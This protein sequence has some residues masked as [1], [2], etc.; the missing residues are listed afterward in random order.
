[1][2]N[3]WIALLL[4]IG[5]GGVARPIAEIPPIDGEGSDAATEQTVVAAPWNPPRDDL[6]VLSVLRQPSES[7]MV[8][9]RVSFDVGSMEDPPGKEGLTS[10]TAALMAGGGLG[11]LSYPQVVERLY[12]MAASLGTHVGRDQTVFVG[13]AH[14]DHIEGFYPLFRDMLLA[15]AL[16]EQDF[17][18]LQ[19]QALS[20]LT[21]GLRGSND[22]ALGQETLQAMLYEGHPYGNPSVGTEA[23]IA[24]ITL[25]DVRDHARRMFCAG[26]ATLGLAGG[27]SAEL[28]GRLRQ[29]LARLEGE[30]C[31]GRRSL[32]DAPEGQPRIWLV[33]K[34][35]AASVAISMGV[36]LDVTRDHPDYA[37]L[38]LAAAYL[39]Q[40]R[41]FAGR[42]MQKMRGDR[43]LNYGDYAYAE[44]FMEHPGTRFPAANVSRRQQ[45]FS[46]WVRPVRR[47]QAHFALR[48]AVR[49]F[50]DFVSEGLTQE[51]FER[52]RGFVRG[53]YALF[54]QT[55]GRRLG[56]ALDDRYY[57]TID[58]WLAALHQRWETLT[59]EEVNAAIARHIDPR[60]LQ[61]AVVTADAE[62]F[63][64]TLASEAESTIRYRGQ[65]PE[66]VREEDPEIRSYRIGIDRDAMH[67]VPV[68]ELFGE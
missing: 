38:T 26:R 59:V 48:M 58:P 60:G 1:M 47:E 68:G 67:I 56:F 22:E 8:E 11:E 2:M 7:P 15:P 51:D 10:L 37:A 21:L 42:L 4:C 17:Q 9:M 28:E 23:G 39:G 27:Y 18:R 40:H 36:H 13:R 55:E 64:D 6:G 61:I 46:V 12:P 65:V 20:S 45:Y 30:Q 29:D 44:H 24:A 54:L 5:C 52:I 3:R 49:E 53:Y 57:D 62:A 50:R 43:G 33:E 41:T 25:E 19:T 66:R 32:P 16:G 14:R 63:A 35:S 31:L 34:D